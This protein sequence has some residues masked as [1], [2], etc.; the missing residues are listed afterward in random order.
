VMQK[1]NRQSPV[2]KKLCINHAIHLAVTKFLYQ[3]HVDIVDKSYS[4]PNTCES[5]EEN[6]NNDSDDD[7][8]E[9]LVNDDNLILEEVNMEIE[10]DRNS[11]LFVQL[12]ALRIVIKFFRI[13]PLKNDFLQEKIKSAHGKEL[14]LKLDVKTKWNSIDPMIERYLE[15]K[16]EVKEALLS[17]NSVHLLSVIDEFENAISAAMTS[18][19][20]KPVGPFLEKEESGGYDCYI[21]TENG[22]KLLICKTTPLQRNNP[23]S[24]GNETLVRCSFRPGLGYA[25]TTRQHRLTRRLQDVKVQLPPPDTR[26]RRIVRHSRRSSTDSS[27][28]KTLP[29]DHRITYAKWSF[30]DSECITL[31]FIF[32]ICQ[33]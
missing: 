33:L 11:N 12:R 5:G 1:Y 32:N 27:A 2:E 16:E 9:V 8:S 6:Y 10:T 21:P 14:E 28:V 31:T 23:P 15:V 4:E 25:I 29:T 19:S 20:R 13:S 3:K 26:R 24:I 30:V 18:T 7:G 22:E 17:F